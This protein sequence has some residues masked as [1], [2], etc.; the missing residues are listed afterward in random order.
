LILMS[1]RLAVVILVVL[2]WSR[3]GFGLDSTATGPLGFAPSSRATQIR[4]EK[5]ALEV[6]SPEKARA[7][8]RALTEEPHVAGT[9]ADYKTAIFVR[10][11]LREW[12]W[13]AEL[14][15]YEV[16]LNYPVVTPGIPRLE[17]VRPTAK[18]LPLMEDPLNADKDSA[19]P[20]AW[21]AFHGYGVSGDV[22]GQV[23]FANLARPEDF[24]TLES[25]GVDVR[26]KIVLARYGGLFRGLKVYNAQKRGAA[27][28]LIYSDPADDGYARGD[29]Y[30]NGPFRPASAIQRG[31]AQFISH[32]PGDPSTPRGPS[33]KGAERIPIDPQNGFPLAGRGSTPDQVKAWEGQ[34]GLK[35]EDY[36]AAIPAL[37]ISYEAARPILEALGGPAVPGGWQGGLPMTYHV[38]PGPA[39]VHFVTQMHYKIRPVWNVIATLAGQVEPERWVL[40]GNHRDAWVYG[41]VDPNSGTAST[42]ETCRA[43]GAAVK[44]GW[45]PRRTLVYASWDAEEYGLVGSTEWAEDHAQELDTK[46]VLMLNV[47][48]AVSGPDLEIDGIP[49][50]RDMVLDAAGSVIDPR[51]NKSLRESWL[52]R[53]RSQWASSGALDLDAGVWNTRAAMPAPSTEAFTPMMGWMGSG[54]DYTPFVAHLGIPAVDIDFAGRYGVYHSIYDNFFWMEK[55]GDP[56]FL[57]HAT[58][59]RLYTIIAMR[60]ASAEVVPLRLVPYGEALREHID[61]L[62]R[63]LVRKARGVTPESGKSPLEFLGLPKL[64]AAVRE[65]QTQAEVLDRAT[66]G[67]AQRDG[68]EPK[69]L[70]NVNDALTRVERAFLTGNGLPGRPWMK[71]AVY[72]PGL[73][74]GY[75]SW[76]LPGVRQAILEDNSKML[77]EQLP[78][79]VQRLQA[80]TEAMANAT[81]LASLAEKP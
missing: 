70:A 71:H 46:A 39:E 15:E 55:F 74:T 35:R 68:V 41:A 28:V 32:Q 78:I 13:S 34:T 24:A 33:T 72:A 10:D 57:I 14:A 36:F 26:G 52:D 61:D 8:L 22:Q 9:P 49:S 54:S 62:R 30:P 48:S 76:P 67:L 23:V 18:D 5:K 47:D 3:T 4:A 38:G 69:A 80:A 31:S 60:A 43:L 11:K 27:G 25:L 1:L 20:A 65:F 59:A 16:L 79:L 29:V 75:A 21:P 42:L 63:I 64:I 37:P 56:E 19:S 50:M 2:L 51:T 58:S 77:D 44:A 73:T 7:W 40:I 81:R 6:P 53:K 17:L 12:G 45:K 66:R